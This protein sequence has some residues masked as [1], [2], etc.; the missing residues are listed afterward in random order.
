VYVHICIKL[1][2]AGIDLDDNYLQPHHQS[3]HHTRGLKKN[4]TLPMLRIGRPVLA[5]AG[6]Q[7]RHMSVEAVTETIAPLKNAVEACHAASG[8]S[9]PV[10]IPLMTC[11]IRLFTTFPLAVWNR[12]RIIKQRSVQPLLAGSVPVIKVQLAQSVTQ[13]GA[14]L[15]PEQITVLAAKERRKRRVQLYKELGCQ[16]WKSLVLPA[17]QVPIFV[18]MSF[19]VRSLVGFDLTGITEFGNVDKSQ[20]WWFKNLVEPDPLGIVP[21]GI[22]ALALSNVE[23]NSRVAPVT[24]EQARRQ[25]RRSGPSVAAAL[26]NISR[27]GSVVFMAISFQA[28]LALQLYWFS[29]NAFSFVQNKTL[30]NFL[31]VNKEPSYPNISKKVMEPQNN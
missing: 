16:N 1:S 17:V 8:L 14:N 5:R 30:D 6:L 12:K 26:T 21:L 24:A 13:K 18:A 3:H 29:S 23:L 7:S 10:F 2:S 28:S 9:W 11:G 19:A 15:T 25:N 4:I 31:P 22:G 27:A 20:F